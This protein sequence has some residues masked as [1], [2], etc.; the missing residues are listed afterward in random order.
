MTHQKPDTT[1]GCRDE[2][3]KRI[4]F[5]DLLQSGWTHLPISGRWRCPACWRALEQ[6]SDK[7]RQS[8]QS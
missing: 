6:L 8:P 2:C 3:G 5:D 4:E 7:G 1:V